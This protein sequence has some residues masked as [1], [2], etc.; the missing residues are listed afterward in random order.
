MLLEI[1]IPNY[2]TYQAEKKVT[3]PIIYLSQVQVGS[4][5]DIWA[6]PEDPNNQKKI[7]LG[8]K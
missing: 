2:Q 8:L 7:G 4:T 5:I 3:I 6:D 1:Q